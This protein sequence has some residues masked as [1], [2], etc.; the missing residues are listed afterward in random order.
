LFSTLEKE[1]M[2][3]RLLTTAVTVARELTVSHNL[4]LITTKS[5]PRDKRPYQ[6][7]MA[8]SSVPDVSSPESSEPSSSRRSEPSRRQREP[9]ESDYLNLDLATPRTVIRLFQGIVNSINEL[10]D[11][12]EIFL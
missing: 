11:L 9:Q 8:E 2:A 1:E 10:I 4:D 3:Q 6:D 7:P 5:S 12:I